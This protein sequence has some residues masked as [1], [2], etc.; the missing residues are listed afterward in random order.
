[1]QITTRRCF[2]LDS[3]SCI[4]YVKDTI[5]NAN[6]NTVTFL[7]NLLSRVFN[8][9]KI[10][11]WMQ[12]TTHPLPRFRQDGVYSICQRYNFEC[13][14][15][16]YVE[17]VLSTMSC[18]QYVKDTILNANHNRWSRTETTA[19][20][21]FNMS[22]IQF[23][24]QI[25]T[26][27]NCVD[28]QGCVYSICQRYNFE[29]KSQRCAYIADNDASC[30]QYVKDTILNANHNCDN[31]PLSAVFRVFN[32]SKIQFWMQITTEIAYAYGV[33]AVYS[34][35]QRYNFECKSQLRTRIG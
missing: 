19:P 18:I 29:C 12:I 30:I 6:H 7:L 5:L 23:W 27:W 34:I 11:F 35:C 33:P 8:M 26:R 17:T 2:A 16:Q 24:M 1:M 3:V 31:W 21:V 10:Q 20:R 9:S 28:L 13:K 25:T 32:M 4:Q 14:S 15:Q 22:K